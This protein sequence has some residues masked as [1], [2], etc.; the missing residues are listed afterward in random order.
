MKALA[1][2]GIIFAISASAASALA[3]PHSIQQFIC[4]GD[5]VVNAYGMAGTA[6]AVN[7]F[8]K[9]VAMRTSLG[10]IQQEKLVDIAIGEGCL[11]AFCIGDVVSNHYGMTGA[12]AAVNP[13]SG[14]VVLRTSLGTLQLEKLSDMLVAYG[15][16]SGYCVGDRIVNKYGMEGVIYALSPYDNKAA[17]QTSLGTIQLENI[18]DLSSTNFCEAYGEQERGYSRYPGLPSDQYLAPSFH[19]YH[20]R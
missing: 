4:P 5:S 1:Q 19:Y 12:I 14:K 16:N 13:Y 3:C 8:Q 18:E 20:R 2:L 7:P 15:C 9:T 17:M 6:V 11:E 10:T